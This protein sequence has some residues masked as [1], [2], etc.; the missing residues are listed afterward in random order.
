VREKWLLLRRFAERLTRAQP[1]LEKAPSS[2]GH[3]SDQEILTE[4]QDRFS[5]QDYA[6]VL[7]GRAATA[8]TPLT[9]GI[10]GRWGSGKTSLMRLIEVALPKETKKGGQLRSI[11]INVWQLSN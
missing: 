1:E 5:F 9:T 7:A 3:W 4:D 2:E 10:F 6:S 8:D 11:W